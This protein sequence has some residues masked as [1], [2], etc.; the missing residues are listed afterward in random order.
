MQATS[1]T[2][3]GDLSLGPTGGVQG[4]VAGKT[5]RIKFRLNLIMSQIASLQVGIIECAT[6]TVLRRID[7]DGSSPSGTYFRQVQGEMLYTPAA[8]TEV[9]LRAV[10]ASGSPQWTGSASA[11]ANDVSILIVE[12][13]ATTQEIPLSGTYT[14]D[15][16]TINQYFDIGAM[17]IS[18]G[19]GTG[20]TP[21]T[22][23]V[24]Y[25]AAPE[26]FTNPKDFNGQAAAATITTTGFSP[27]TQDSGGATVNSS[28]SW[29]A[30]GL[31]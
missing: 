26:V 6:N 14:N 12:E 11:A 3:G 4:L 16:A 15:Q 9:F 27:Q 20:G 7:A 18:W 1:F 2:Q 25:S 13:V 28:I 5:Y 24:A 17:R 10:S 19:S 30:I 22:F 21:V 8:N 31:R 23:P 29:M